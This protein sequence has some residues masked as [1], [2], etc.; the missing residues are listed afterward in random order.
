MQKI[1]C[2]RNYYQ[3]LCKT[4]MLLYQQLFVK[5]DMDGWVSK[6]QTGISIVN[7]YCCML[8]LLQYT[9]TERH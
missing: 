2:P 9:K 1:I 7:R 8:W 5:F 6:Y 3:H 4:I